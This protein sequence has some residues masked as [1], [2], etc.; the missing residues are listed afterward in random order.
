MFF[1]RSGRT[2]AYLPWLTAAG[3]VLRR[4]FA[5]LLLLETGAGAAAM[6][7]SSL[8]L[9]SGPRSMGLPIGQRFIVSAGFSGTPFR[10]CAVGDLILAEDV[11][12]SD[13]VLR[14]S[15]W[16]GHS[17]VSRGRLLTVSNI[18]GLP[19]EKR[20]VPRRPK[21]ER[22]PWIWRPPVVARLCRE[23]GV[24]FG[25]LRYHFRRCGYHLSE[26]LLGLLEGGEVRP[27]RL[28]AAI[29]DGRVYRGALCGSAPTRGKLLG[30]GGR[31]G[32]HS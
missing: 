18:V 30:V 19:A 27:R 12:D 7:E 8:W 16:P 1:R 6:E 31:S 21:V 13:G 24:L 15:T 9:F 17:L 5:H 32:R 11:C 3:G 29:L 26:N 23:A 20:S 22:S 10:L 28:L 2:G 4:W 14:P 25:C